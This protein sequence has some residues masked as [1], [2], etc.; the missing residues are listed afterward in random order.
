MHQAAPSSSR[1]GEKAVTLRVLFFGPLR[2]L[3]QAETCEIPWLAKASA[4]EFWIQLLKVYPVVE[5]ARGTIRLAR[6]NEFLAAHDEIH[7]GDEIAL[8]PPVSGG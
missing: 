2:T 4:D 7:P 3:V 6:S 5:S 1:P 8:I